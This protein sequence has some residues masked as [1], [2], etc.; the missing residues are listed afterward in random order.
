MARMK[1]GTAKF[2]RRELLKLFR[3]DYLPTGVTDVAT[4][5]RSQGAGTRMAW[6]PWSLMMNVALL[7]SGVEL[8]EAMPDAGRGKAPSRL[9]RYEAELRAW[10]RRRTIA[11]NKVAKY[12]RLVR[13]H[14]KLAEQEA[15]A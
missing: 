8:A 1:S 10:K 2:V 3:R 4:R 12:A 15:K 14:R 7:Q 6:Q 13:Y 5:L 9:E 11:R